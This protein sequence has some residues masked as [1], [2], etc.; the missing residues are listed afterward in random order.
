[1]FFLDPYYNLLSKADP[2]AYKVKEILPKAEASKKSYLVLNLRQEEQTKVF[3]GH[4]DG[5]KFFQ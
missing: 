2:D 1:M 5:L 3:L 4:D